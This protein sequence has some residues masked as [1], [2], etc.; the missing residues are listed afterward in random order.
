MICNLPE[1]REGRIK[2]IDKEIAQAKKKLGILKEQR[3]K[4]ALEGLKGG[5]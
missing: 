1:G 3:T 4:E 2:A 5:Y